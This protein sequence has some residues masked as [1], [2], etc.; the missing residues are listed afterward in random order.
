MSQWVIGISAK[1]DSLSNAQS[2]EEQCWTKRS[3]YKLPPL[4]FNLKKEAYQPQAVSFGPY[5]H[6]KPHLK[7]MEDHKQRAL[8]HF[9]KRSPVSLQKIFHSMVEVAEELKASYDSLE[10]EWQDNTEKFVQLM[11]VDGC[12]MLEILQEATQEFGSDA[13]ARESG[14]DAAAR[15]YMSDYSNDDPIFGPH[16][17]LYAIPF[18]RRDM[19]LIENQLPMLVLF[20]LKGIKENVEEDMETLNK[21]ILNF[22]GHVAHGSKMGKRLHILDL[23]RKSLLYKEPKRTKSTKLKGDQGPYSPTVIRSA[24]E[25]NEA[26]IRFKKSKT[27]SLRDISFDSGVLRLPKFVVDDT[28]ESTFLNLIAFERCHVGAGHAITSF[29]CFMDNIIDH[30]RDISLLSSKGIIHNVAGT[31]KAAAN[32]FNTMSKDLMMDSSNDLN[33]VTMSIASYW[34]KPWH[35][36]RAMLIHTYF[37]SPWAIV[38]VVAAVILFALATVSTV[39]DVMGK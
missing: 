11:I 27:E 35:K 16:G 19:L 6:G 39:Y 18:I 15:V 28:T 29:I 23:Y 12:F 10:A 22:Y 32:L 34:K 2:Q 3:I 1:L 14:N 13:A 33:M 30:D 5:H 36:W 20:K 26:G 24:T 9:L 8:L 21:Q 4:I 25:L 31:D 7:P 37:R 17:K 38:S